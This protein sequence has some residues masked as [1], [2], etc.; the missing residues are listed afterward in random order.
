VS[1]IPELL[2][3][4]VASWRAWL[5]ENHAT[6]PGVRLVLAKKGMT[7]P[8]RLTCDDAQTSGWLRR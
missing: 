8:T 7:E 2:V 4:D 3:T 5:A 1:E 6:S